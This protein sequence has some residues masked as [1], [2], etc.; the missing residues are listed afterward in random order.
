MSI[1]KGINHFYGVEFIAIL[2]SNVFFFVLII[3]IQLFQR[4]INGSEDFNRS[5]ND[6]VRGFGK[7]S[8]E[9]WLGK[10]QSNELI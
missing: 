6:Y 3:D 10:L 9:F 2:I 8:G 4:R 5:F 7:L 1:D